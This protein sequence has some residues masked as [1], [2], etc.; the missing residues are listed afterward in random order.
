[1][2][3]TR[4]SIIMDYQNAMRQADRISDAADKLAARENEIQQ[5]INTIRISWIGE[6]AS[7][8]LRKLE[9]SKNN[10]TKLKANLKNISDVTRRIAR[11]TYD[12]E[13]ATLEISQRR[14]Y[15]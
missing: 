3:K 1:M 13:M 7:D 14:S 15:H 11:R 2:A 8:Y 9:K 6:N 12:T 5:Y 4:F 10:L